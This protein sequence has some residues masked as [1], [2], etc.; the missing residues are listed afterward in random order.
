LFFAYNL[1]NYGYIFKAKERA[2]N[3]NASTYE[4][5]STNIPPPLES[6]KP[7]ESQQSKSDSQSSVVSPFSTAPKP[8]ISLPTENKG[9]SVGKK[10]P[11]ETDLPT[12]SP[13]NPF[14]LAASNSEAKSSAIPVKEITPK[15]TEPS[16][17]VFDS[18][19]SFPANQTQP[20]Y[21]PSNQHFADNARKSLE[22]AKIFEKTDTQSK[23]PT[24]TKVQPPPFVPRSDPYVTKEV[25]PKESQDLGAQADD[26]ARA[27]KA[28]RE[29]M[30]G[31][32]LG[33]VGGPTT[34]KETVP[35]KREP[36]DISSAAPSGSVREAAKTFNPFGPTKTSP[37]AM[38]AESEPNSVSGIDLPI[39]S[40]GP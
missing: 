2:A 7:F 40:G 3:R 11:F 20:S 14:S 37:V 30:K 31:L 13:F 18:P 16:P 28:A 35:V 36:V 29:A 34:L 12:S 21:S 24:A 22:T 15:A 10:S 26:M 27:A 17:T 9:L 25:K 6:V 4:S 1:L 23:S 32:S 5:P 8:S 38:V 19:F 39:S 33:G